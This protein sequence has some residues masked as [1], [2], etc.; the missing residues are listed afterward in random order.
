MDTMTTIS[1]V[2]NHLQT[3]GY[4]T[5]FNLNDNCLVC[6]GNS[7]RIHPED[8][9]IDKHYRFEGISDPGDEAVIYAISSIKHNERGT[10][11]NGY[12]IYSEKA[13][14]DLIDLLKENT[15]LAEKHKTSSTE[16]KFNEATPQRPEGDRMLDAPLVEMDIQR[17]KEQIKQEE[18]W[19]NSDR[20]AITIFKS[21][22]MRVVL[23]AMH[24][25]AEMKT[26]TAPGTISIQVIE[27]QILFHTE[28]K[29][30]KLIEDQMLA[31]HVG[32][33]HSVQALDESVFLLTINSGM[34]GK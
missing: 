7:L 4:T 3:E 13:V 27:G 11:L 12:G 6:H 2:L 16:E 32:I 8:F 9:V 28:Q 29:S 19:R 18:T 25:G 15:T 20:N 21:D 1:E 5:D 33:P 17:Y 30:V 23:I 26:H 10:L 31:L 14:D 24:K 22:G 34:S